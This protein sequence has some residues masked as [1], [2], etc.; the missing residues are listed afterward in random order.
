MDFLTV[1]REFNYAIVKLQDQAQNIR[2][3][4]HVPGFPQLQTSE[5]AEDEREKNEKGLISTALFFP[6]VPNYRESQSPSFYLS[7]ALFC[8]HSSLTTE[9]LSLPRFISRS[10]SFV[11]TRPQLPRSLD[12][13]VLSLA[14]SV[15]FSLI[16]NYRDPQSPSFY[17]S[18]VP[19][20]HSSSTNENLTPPRF[21][22]R[23]PSFFSLGPNYREP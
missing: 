16:P 2:L 10:L 11:F 1:E 13:L 19:F 3:A 5:K 21:I 22:S 23:S 7:L 14:R 6:L 12:P 8:L 9:S 20:F 15:L 18:L 17:L 4:Q